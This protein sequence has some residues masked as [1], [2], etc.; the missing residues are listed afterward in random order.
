MNRKRYALRTCNRCDE[1]YEPTGAGQKFCSKRCRMNVGKRCKR[2]GLLLTDRRARRLFCSR[3]CYKRSF[4][5]PPRLTSKGY[6]L[7]KVEPDTPGTWSE[8]RML[9]HRHVMQES[10]GR[11]LESHETVHHINGVKTDNR[12]E[13]LQLR[14]GRHGKGVVFVCA[15]CG[16]HNVAAS[17]IGQPA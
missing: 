1:T 15:D 10:L 6:V 16:S 5:V 17:P 2:C 14:Q 4:I 3:E 7:V 9:Q 11:P 13:N 8:S 12:I